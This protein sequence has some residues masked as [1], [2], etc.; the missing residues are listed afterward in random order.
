MKYTT[1]YIKKLLLTDGYT[2]TSE[3]ISYHT[4]FTYTC[5]EG[6][7]GKSSLPNWLKGARCKVCAGQVVT[8]AQ[9]KASF[10]REGYTLLSTDY[11]NRVTPLHFICP[12]GHAHTITWSSWSQ[13]RRC[14]I[15][16]GHYIDFDMVKKSFKER[17]YILLSTE[18]INNTTKL[19]YICPVGHNGKI[20]WSDWHSGCGCN[21]C[22]GTKRYS[23]EEVADKFHVEGYTLLSPHY[24]HSHSYLDYLCDKGHKHQTIFTNWLSGQRCPTCAEKYVN[25]DDVRK[26]FNAV[27]YELITQEYKNQMDIL[28][29]ICDNGHTETTTWKAFNQGI[30]C[31]SCST[32]KPENEIAEFIKSCNVVYKQRDRTLIHPLEIDILIPSHSLAIEYCG[33]FW[34]SD[35]GGHKNSKYHQHKMQLC[36]AKNYKLLTIFGDEW[37]NK[38]DVVKSIIRNNLGLTGTKIYARN[39]SIKFISIG[40]GVQFLQNNHLIE[41]SPTGASI[42]VGAYHNNILVSVMTF[43]KSKSRIKNKMPGAYELSRFCSLQNYNVVGIASRLL[44][45]FETHIEWTVISS[46]ADRRWSNG[47]VYTKL[48]FTQ[49]SI[50]EPKYSY[51]TNNY[52]ERKHRFSYRKRPNE[53][54]DKTEWELRQAE[55]LD[56]IWDCGNLKFEKLNSIYC[57][58]I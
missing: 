44:K 27:N 25:I 50:V 57:I 2:L 37:D 30:R 36:A 10:E 55:G 29:F 1:E 51:L 52:K 41:K 53:S 49:V 56:R 54:K 5:K 40:E 16:S 28:S 21:I 39:C 4:P 32:S 20:T 33:L 47:D 6:H 42:F 17:N 24:K 15:D 31:R 11:V 58:H 14:A 26:A 8:Y 19:S 7:I 35:V 12:S 46:L 43:S 23:Y 45:Y 48:G 22:G 34:H 13:G 3:Y 9:V 38:R 18:Y